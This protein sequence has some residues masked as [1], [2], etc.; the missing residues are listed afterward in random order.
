MNV[1]LAYNTSYSWYV[2]ASDGEAV[3]RSD[4]WTFSTCKNVSEG[5]DSEKYRTNWTIIVYLDG[6]NNLDTYAQKELNE[7]KSAELNGSVSVIVLQDG[8]KNG[9]SRCHTIV[10]GSFSETSLAE[11]CPEWGEEVNMGSGETLS[12]FTD[13]A[14]RHYPAKHY[15]LELWN[16]GYGWRG[17]C[18]DETNNDKLTL[19]EIQSALATVYSSRQEKIDVLTYTACKMG[20]VETAHGLDVYVDYFVSS[21]ESMSATGL[22][23]KKIVEA[24]GNMSSGSAMVE[25][26]V[27]VFS[28]LYQ[29]APTATIA[30][31]DLAHMANLSASVDMFA[32]L[33]SNASHISSSV[34]SN[35]HEQAESFGGVGY[36]D[37]YDFARLIEEL[38]GDVAIDDAAR[39]VIDN[40]TRLTCAEWHGDQHPGAHGISIYFPSYYLSQYED[41]SFAEDT[42]WD[43]FL[44]TYA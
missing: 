7:L 34:I 21:Q 19:Q 25:Y 14:F 40:V 15:M 11:I 18:K 3:T 31:W 27:D 13:Y 28:A 39:G 4:T 17:I 23:H 29:D 30:G 6:D 10:N 12:V 37:L 44:Q 36:R 35:A 38:S 42:F 20:G 43:E 5:S 22:P 1:T 32:H 41:T 33:L 9:D 26:I 2:V 8:Q 16:H 24:A